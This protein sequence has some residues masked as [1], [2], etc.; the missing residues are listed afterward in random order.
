M[1]LNMGIR[2][3]SIC[4]SRYIAKANPIVYKNQS[5]GQVLKIKSN[6]KTRTSSTKYSFGIRAPE[7]QIIGKSEPVRKL[8]ELIT[9]VAANDSRILITGETGVGK[10]VVAQNLYAESIRSD[11]NFVKINCAGLTE[12]LLEIEIPCFDQTGTNR[13]FKTKSGGLFDEIIG[14]ILFLDNIDLLSPAH[15]SEIL[16]LMQNVG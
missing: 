4:Q 11:K 3:K 10:E 14:G 13:A 6:A 8:K 1:L 16:P 7:P 9:K 12:S 5:V 15:Q 2:R